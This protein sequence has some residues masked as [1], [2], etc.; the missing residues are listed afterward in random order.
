MAQIVEE[1]IKQGS[2]ITV[3]NQ[4]KRK[5]KSVSKLNKFI[6]K[7]IVNDKFWIMEQSGRRIGTLQKDRE[8]F[9]FLKKKKEYFESFNK[10]MD[11]YKIK[12]IENK[13]SKNI[14][15]KVTNEIHGY[16]V[17]ETPYNSILDVKHGMPLYTKSDK[18]KSYFCAGYYIIKFKKLWSPNFC[19][20]LITLSRYEYLGPFKT[21]L[22]QRDALKLINKKE[23]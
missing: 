11:T 18:S 13:K 7:P 20:K 19:P 1:F 9:I 14:I 2:K 23:K 15:K 17:K 22:E 10:L 12:F 21:K 8:R 16:P 4:P 5:Q 6:A 3:V